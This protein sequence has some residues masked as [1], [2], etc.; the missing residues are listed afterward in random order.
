MTRCDESP[1]AAATVGAVGDDDTVVV[2]LG[3]GILAEC[4]GSGCSSINVRDTAA[5][6]ATAVAA[7]TAAL[8]GATRA[9]P[10]MIGTGEFDRVFAADPFTLSDDEKE[11]EARVGA[12]D[13]D[14]AIM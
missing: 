14:I 5:G 12:D 1:G 9:P 4:D 2:A 8:A 3:S 6:A 7:G 10:T 13:A 11:E